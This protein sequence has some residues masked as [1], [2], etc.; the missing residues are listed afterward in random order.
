MSLS[1]STLLIVVLIFVVLYASYSA[2]SLKHKIY[3]T[4]RKKDR[5]ILHKWAKEEQSK[6]DFDGGWYDVVPGSTVLRMWDSGI[7]YFF[8]VW[9]RCL[10]FRWDSSKPLNPDTF[11]NTYRPEERKQLDMADDISALER[12]NVQAFQGAKGAKGFLERWMPILILVGFV[13]IVYMVM[14]QN[15]RLDMLGNSTNFIQQQLNT[16]IQK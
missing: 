5:T 11:D 16:L 6:I 15:K 2:R 9:V 3:C 13:I 14:Q 4:F 8:P 12:G 10:D 1:P 7:H